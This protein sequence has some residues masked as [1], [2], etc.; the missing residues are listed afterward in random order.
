MEAIDKKMTLSLQNI[1]K[2]YKGGKVQALTDTN[3]TLTPGLYG[4]LGPNGAGKTTLMNLIAGSISPDTG[5]VIYDGEPTSKMGLDFLNILGYMPQQQGLYD[6]FTANRFLW[7]FAAL[8]GMGKQEAKNKIEYLFDLVN[9]RGD[10]H[11]KLKTYS[12]GMKQRV[13]LAQALLNDPNILLLDEPTA[14]LDP[15]E[16]V[17][18]RNF[19]SEIASEKIVLLATHIVS[20]VEY[21]AKEVIFLKNGR[22]IEMGRQS[23]ILPRFASKVWQATLDV[24]QIRH[25]GEAYAVSTILGEADGRFT[26]KIVSDNIPPGFDAIPATPTLEDVYVYLYELGSENR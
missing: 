15:K 26:V 13:L 24:K 5:A 4:L 25:T 12:G 9:L 20:D 6:E 2:A 1:S 8:K 18:V 3:I 17:R 14:G 22:I 7:Y 11:K 23:V 19:I 21:A 10:A 16:R